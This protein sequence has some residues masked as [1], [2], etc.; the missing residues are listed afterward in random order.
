MDSNASPEQKEILETIRHCGKDEESRLKLI[1]L[2]SRILRAA[3]ADRRDIVGILDDDRSLV[4]YLDQF[5]QANHYKTMSATNSKAFLNLCS[6]KKPSLILLDIGMPDMDGGEMMNILHSN[7]DTAE[8]PIIF[9]SGIID[10]NEESYL[11]RSSVNNI[12]YLAKPFENEVLISEINQSL[13]KSET[14]LSYVASDEV[15]SIRLRI[16]RRMNSSGLMI[17]SV[18]M[19]IT[20]IEELMV[21]MQ[22]T[23]DNLIPV[24]NTLFEKGKV[25]IESTDF[26]E[27]W[28][29]MN[30]THPDKSI[31]LS[32][33]DAYA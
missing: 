17:K 4:K 19:L 23:R 29:L 18:N 33:L 31:V 11:N 14:S 21:E 12:R 20:K 10:K 28:E 8:I 1:S 22:Y 5:L 3:E 15:N 24:I 27:K 6:S 7:P 26:A 16:T 30:D 32:A 13:H 25:Y 2:Y 9:M